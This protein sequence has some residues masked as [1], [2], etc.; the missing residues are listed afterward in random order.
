MQVRDVSLVLLED[1]A[2]SVDLLLQDLTHL[3]VGALIL[4]RDVRGGHA[5]GARLDTADRLV[6]LR[7]RI[8]GHALG[9]GLR[10][11]DSESQPR[12]LHCCHHGIA[13]LGSGVLVADA[14][15]G[16][17][18]GRLRRLIGVRLVREAK[19]RPLEP[20]GR[21]DEILRHLADV[22]RLSEELLADTCRDI[23]HFKSSL[24]CTSDVL[25]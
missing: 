18:D 6:E 10:E 23:R 19:I 21:G 24:G 22:D 3:L 8:E 17:D 4:A 12:G 7:P 9:R 16:E 5:A 11:V 2:E 20:E 13:D 1:L 25:V 14:V 15:D